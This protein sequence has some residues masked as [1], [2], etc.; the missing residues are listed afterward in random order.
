MADGSG[1]AYNLLLFAVLVATGSPIDVSPEL[2]E[3]SCGSSGGVQSK[4]LVQAADL[5][6][7]LAHMSLLH[8][9]H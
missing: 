1:L 9:L 4:H 3:G 2:L 5:L 6:V 8:L 7:Q